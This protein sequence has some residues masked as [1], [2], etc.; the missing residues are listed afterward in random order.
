MKR[1]SYLLLGL[2]AAPL[3]GQVSDSAPGLIGRVDGR[4]YISPTGYFRIPIPVLPELGGTISDT[5][6]VVTFQDSFTVHVSIGVFPQDATQR[7]E[8]S[9][10]GL[11]DYLAYFFG[12]YVMPDFQN[13]FPGG[14]V[15]SVGFSENVMGG[16]LIAYTLLPGGSMFAGKSSILGTTENAPVA[17]RGN[18]IF[19]RNN[20]I[21]V[22]TTELAE[23]VTE[24]SA[25]K[26]T[27]AEEDTILRD[28]LVDLA[29]KMEFARPAQTNP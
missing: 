7:W 20:V 14:K 13:A 8:L 17:K 28:R 10:R 15:E 16:A 23:R 25:Y 26:K 6:N 12:T 27:K 21:Y 5:D 11:R 9:T 1:V 18:L 29:Q 24:R 22:I 3:F 19:V 4:M 2:L